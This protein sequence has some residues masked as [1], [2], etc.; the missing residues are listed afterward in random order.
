MEEIKSQKHRQ[1]KVLDRRGS[2][3]A[4]GVAGLITTPATQAK[5]KLMAANQP[6]PE[7]DPARFELMKYNLDRRKRK[8][9]YGRVFGLFGTGP[10][11]GAA[12]KAGEPTMTALMPST[13]I[14]VGETRI[15]VDPTAG[16]SVQTISGESK[17]DTEPD[18]RKGVNRDSEGPAVP[19]GAETEQN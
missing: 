5:E 16:V 12:A 19:E 13:P 4:T 15:E 7:P 3:L 18:A 10:N 2:K 17:L 11:V 6:V 9:L 1:Q 14:G 8:S